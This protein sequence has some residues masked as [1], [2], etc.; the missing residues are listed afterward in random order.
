MRVRLTMSRVCMQVLAPT[1]IHTGHRQR[2]R[3]LRASFCIRY[4]GTQASLGGLSELRVSAG[5]QSRYCTRASQRPS[6]I[7]GT[8][9]TRSCSSESVRAV[10]NRASS[11]W[12]RL[13]DLCGQNAGM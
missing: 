10:T 1:P 7:S 4:D 8:T 3:P 2:K 13:K 9:T 6:S 11:V 12:L 5:R